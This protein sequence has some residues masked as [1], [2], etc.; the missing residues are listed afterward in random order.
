MSCR[1]PWF[2]SDVFHSRLY[3]LQPFATSF[4]LYNDWL[5]RRGQPAPPKKGSFMARLVE[6]VA[7]AFHL[8]HRV[9]KI[10]LATSGQQL[11]AT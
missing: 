11:L 10:W 7:V 9:L 4:F 2:N 3:F 5:N 1:F 8:Y 6:G